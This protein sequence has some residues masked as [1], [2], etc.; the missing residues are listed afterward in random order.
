VSEPS[1][2]A[3]LADL[4]LPQRSV[5]VCRFYLGLSE[6][7]TADALGIRPGTVKS[8]LHR[9]LQRLQPRLAHLRFEES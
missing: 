5:I 8:R 3:A 1:V 9:A 4:D 2:A 7:E 6:S